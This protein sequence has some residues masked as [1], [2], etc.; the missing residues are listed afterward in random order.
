MSETISDLKEKAVININDG[1][2]LGYACDFGIDICSGQLKSLIIP[3]ECECF[4][5]KR[6][7][8]TVIPWDKIVKIGEDAILVDAHCPPPSRPSCD[9]RRRHNFFIWRL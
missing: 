4:G 1:R 7:S 2:K 9:C 5:L 8:D 3:G 6:G